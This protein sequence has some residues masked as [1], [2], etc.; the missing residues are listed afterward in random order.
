M[1]QWSI[2]GEST[3]QM[4]KLLQTKPTSLTLEFWIMDLFFYPPR[5]VALAR[6]RRRG[7]AD[8]TRHRDYEERSHHYDSL[9]AA[10]SRAEKAKKGYHAKK[11][12]PVTHM[13][14]LTIV[15]ISSHSRNHLL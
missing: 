6:L 15:R 11:D 4:D 5:L 8:I 3:F 1:S 9:L 14:D 12:Y 7:F 2:L 13:N 10:Y